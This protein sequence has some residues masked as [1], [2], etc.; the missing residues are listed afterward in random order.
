MSMMLSNYPQSTLQDVY[1]SCF[2]DY[3]GPAHIIANRE[4]ARRYIEYEL[5]HSTL[6]DTLYYEP[7]G[8]RSQYVRV[9]LSVVADSLISIDDFADAFYRSAPAQTPDVSLQWRAEWGRIATLVRSL[10]AELLPAHPQLSTLVERFSADS[11]SITR[12]LDEGKY[13]MHHSEPYGEAYNPHYRIIR[14]DIFEQ[15]ILPRLYIE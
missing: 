7:C 3:F 9:N 6:T 2:Q 14:R 1:K 10:A 11:A 13:V 5:A 8:W 12:M 4:A 15:E